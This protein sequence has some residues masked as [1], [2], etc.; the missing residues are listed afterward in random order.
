METLW[1]GIPL[2]ND[3]GSQEQCDRLKKDNNLVQLAIKMVRLSHALRLR[4][5][6]VHRRMLLVDMVKSRTY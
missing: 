1:A 5:F 6:D 3:G 4:Q 2:S